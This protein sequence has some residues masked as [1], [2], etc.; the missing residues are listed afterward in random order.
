MIQKIRDAR[1]S[2]FTGIMV[3]ASL[4][5]NRPTEVYME[6]TQDSASTSAPMEGAVWGCNMQALVKT[7]DN[8][9]QT[10]GMI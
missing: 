5:T 4:T 10:R 1:G 7:I 2:A 3:S 6:T 9:K 8:Q